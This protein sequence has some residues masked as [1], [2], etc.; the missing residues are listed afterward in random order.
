[1]NNH[2]TH[3]IGFPTKFTS[4][5]ASRFL[6]TQVVVIISDGSG[7]SLPTEFGLVTCYYMLICTVSLLSF[8][9]ASPP[10]LLV[11]YTIIAQHFQRNLL[12]SK[13]LL[14]KTADVARTSHCSRTGQEE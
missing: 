2:H 9:G 8:T 14:Q 5:H 7:V 13:K 4:T 3:P 6:L 12:S 1:M 10:T 11:S